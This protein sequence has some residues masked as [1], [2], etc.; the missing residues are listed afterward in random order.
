NCAACS[1]PSSSSTLESAGLAP[2][3]TETASLTCS[4]AS[5]ARIRVAATR[6]PWSLLGAWLCTANYSSTSACQS[7]DLHAPFNRCLFGQGR[8]VRLGVNQAHR[9]EQR[10]RRP[11]ASTVMGTFVV[12]AASPLQDGVA[13]SPFLD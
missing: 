6:R 1:S 10:R 7:V 8:A 13:F 3:P 5:S 9:I 12:G 4:N 11:V 2:T